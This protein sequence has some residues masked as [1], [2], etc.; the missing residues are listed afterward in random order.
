MPKLILRARELREIDLSFLFLPGLFLE[1]V[2]FYRTQHES[3]D[4]V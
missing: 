3:F 2:V 4:V 1:R